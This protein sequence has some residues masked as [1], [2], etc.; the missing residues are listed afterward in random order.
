[1]IKG[2]I[3][4]VVTIL[5]VFSTLSFAKL[6]QTDISM[7]YVSIFNRASEGSGNAFWQT[8]S[9]SMEEVA[10][11]ML[12]TNNAHEYFGDSLDSNEDFV[13]HIY[14]NTLNK[15]VDDDPKGI[16]YW[17]KLL[18]N[19]TSRSAMIVSF[20]NAI[21]KYAD[22][23]NPA[24][25]RFMNRVTVSNYM[26][27]SVDKTPEDYK[28]STSFSADLGMVN[29]NINGVDL[30]K[31]VIDGI[32]TE[33][34]ENDNSSQKRGTGGLIETNDMLKDVP[35]A[36]TPSS[37]LGIE[38]TLPTSYDLSKDMPPVRSQG[39][40]GSC[41]SWAVG[42]YLKSYHEHIEHDTT[43]GTGDDYSGVF[44][45]SF[46]YNKVRANKNS[47]NSGS[48]ILKN[49]EMLA[50]SGISSW[51]NM[52]YT[53]KNCNAKPSNS[54]TNEAKC[55]KVLAYRIVPTN[56]RFSN[57]DM[58]YH[59]VDEKPIVVAL[60][61][62]DEFSNPKN[63]IEGEY[64][65]KEYNEN[66]TGYHAVVVV[67]YDDNK[68]AFKIINSWG[69]DW[70]NNG[71]LWIDYTVF[72]KIVERAYIVVDAK[73][74]CEEGSSYL[75]INKQAL[76]FNAKE[77]GT[78]SKQTFI[79]S[80]TG[81]SEF[82]ISEIRVPNGYKV[83]WTEGTLQAGATQ[84]VTVTFSPTEAKSYSGK[85]IILHSA[86]NGVNSL[87]ISGIGTS[88]ERGE[89]FISTWKTDNPGKS[90][91]NQITIPTYET[92]EYNYNYYVDWGDGKTNKNVTGDIT[93][94]YNTK[95]TYKIKIS[96]VFPHLYFS[97]NYSK[98]SNETSDSQKL[99]SIEQWGN[100][101]WKSM[102]GTFVNCFNLVG[103][104]RDKPNLSYVK[105]MRWMF[106]G[107]SN[108]NQ[109]IG[110]WD[111][112][113]VTTMHSMF[114]G[115]SKFNQDIGNWNISNVTNMNG[116]FYGASKFNQDIG[117]WN[118]SNVTNM[119]WMFSEASKFNQD[120][121]NWNV[122]NV[123]TMAGL[124]YKATNFNQKLNHWDISNV[125]NMNWMFYEASK[126]NQDIDN[127]N[128]SNVITMA[129][130]FYKATNF[131]QK[132]NNW[133]VSNVIDMRWM[134][135]MAS[136][137]NQNI[138]RWNVSNVKTIKYDNGDVVSAMYYMF[139]GT[140]ALKKIPSWYHE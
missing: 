27:N 113:N 102:M 39:K 136:S 111:V 140:D 62:L 63:K 30:A 60:V 74:E 98:E 34:E 68:N 96:G 44:S 93:H 78:S 36:S 88:S 99:L 46:L 103:K 53:D 57:M 100:I 131:N 83:N 61:I 123:I 3:L 107:A 6:T 64:I 95:G 109:N 86:D 24:Y 71:Y 8:V 5:L 70:G 69:T 45:P 126:F 4:R 29:D 135:N 104:A 129:G 15:T 76:T 7:L 79:I 105:D 124:F 25:N 40:Q 43:Y 85:I 132:L 22:K 117:N 90:S 115:A 75:S 10:K 35:T 82:S 19:G 51:N 128:V 80:N 66:G 133:D 101:K 87:T 139:Y 130:V 91:S 77:V 47:C 48:Y 18:D 114:N 125:T 137:F 1:M 119:N 23:E 73:G 20:I 50:T 84:S 118:I 52:P 127:W 110:N 31:S 17:T 72:K 116:M 11:K 38:S 56:N 21:V 120:I 28:T 121:D 26:A 67:G 134:F 54:A 94:T 92:D 13:K 106:Y 33:N 122:S 2:L 41:A 65:Q 89:E 16:K 42:Y 9:S 14:K 12:E 55:S 49:L 138:E 37:S 81:S 108:F 112:S 97:K 59:L 32:A 58:K